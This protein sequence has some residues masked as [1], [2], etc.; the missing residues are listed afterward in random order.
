M[1][2]PGP[3]ELQQRALAEAKR[4]RQPK[5]GR[6][7]GIVKGIAAADQPRKLI[8]FA[9]KAPNVRQMTKLHPKKIE[10]TKP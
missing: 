10:G 9:G 3:K 6:K 2:P 4:K 7:P 5:T 1:S 8:P